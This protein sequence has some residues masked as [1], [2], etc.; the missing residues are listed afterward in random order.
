MKTEVTGEINETDF[1]KSVVMPPAL[2]A[3]L[4]EALD[5]RPESV[6][7]Q[8]CPGCNKVRVSYCDGDGRAATIE[9]VADDTEEC[10]GSTV[11]RLCSHDSL[12]KFLRRQMN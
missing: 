6:V 9:G 4:L 10:D 7:A 11:M 3:E 8:Q 12:R 5:K 1:G 2:I